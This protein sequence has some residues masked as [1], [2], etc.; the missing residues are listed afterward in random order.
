MKK[1]I[2][3]TALLLTLVMLLSLGLTAC[4]GEEEQPAEPSTQPTET[5]PVTGPSTEPVTEEYTEPIPEGHNQVTFYWTYDGTYENCDMWIWW[6]DVAGKGYL[7]HECD[8]GA[9][10]IVNVPEE[11]EEVGFIVRRDCSEPGGSSWG[12]ATKD[13]EQDRFAVVE[14]R[15]TFIY[16]QPGDPAQYFSNDGGKTLDMAKKF[17]LAGMTDAN[18][19]KYSITPKTTITD[20]SQVK[21]YEGD[22][23]IEVT[24]VSTLGT[25]ATTGYV[26]LAE[27]LDLS[28]NYRITIEGYGEKAVVP[29]DIFDSQFFADNYHYDGNDLG[30]VIHG[31]ETTFKVRQAMVWKPI[32]P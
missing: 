29:T 26:E 1:I 8:Y 3:L 6:G 21:V 27:S 4:G 13:Y 30:A 24:A 10:V 18:Q 12:S 31:S 14:G 9:K 22:R 16:L 17:A 28:K 32:R 20:L 15:E 2:R 7:F 5:E 25:E 23:E 11:V 19:I